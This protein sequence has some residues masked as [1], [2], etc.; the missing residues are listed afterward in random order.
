MRP[1]PDD[2]IT[3]GKKGAQYNPAIVNPEI[4]MQVHGPLLYFPPVHKKPAVT[5]N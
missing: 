5:E 4:G 2:D 3:K 1:P